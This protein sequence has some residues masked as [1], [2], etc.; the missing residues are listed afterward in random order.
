M[1]IGWINL[2]KDYELSMGGGNAYRSY[3][4][5]SLNQLYDIEPMGAV[6][7]KNHKISSGLNN[8]YNLINL[9]GRKDLWVREHLSTI[10]LP[11]DR[12]KGKNLIVVHHVDSDYLAYPRF[13]KLLDKLFYH[14]LK[15]IDELVV[16]SQYWKKHFELLGYNPKVIYNCFNFDDFKFTNDELIDFKNKYSLCDKPIVY[17]GNCQKAK[18]VVE[19]YDVL[20]DLDVHLVTSGKQRVQI[21]A[22]NLNLD[23]RDYLRLLKASSVVV[24]MSKMNEGWCRT[25]HEAMLCKTP[26]VGSGK[27]G[28]AELLDGGGQIICKDFTKLRNEVEYLLN[29]PEIGENGYIYASQKKFTIEFFEREWIELLEDISS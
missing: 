4:L 25:A 26:V 12:T 7:D 2:P 10:T 18:G 24:T 22:L 23:Y 15:Y 8:V 9:N 6:F 20:K 3:L 28:M 11:F 13:S 27:G 19:A 16:V 5:L 17:L 29:H 21:P 1:G 14:N